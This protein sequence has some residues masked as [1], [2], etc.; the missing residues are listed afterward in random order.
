MIQKIKTEFLT[1]ILLVLGVFFIPSVQFACSTCVTNDGNTYIWETVILSALPF[2]IGGPIIY[3]MVRKHK[4]YNAA[5]SV[6][7]KK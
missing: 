6:T 4:E 1:L 3:W 7:Q 5:N 2:L